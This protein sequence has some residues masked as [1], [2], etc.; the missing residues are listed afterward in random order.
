MKDNGFE[1]LEDG[2]I[3]RNVVPNKN[4]QDQ[5]YSEFQQLEY[6]V[7]HLTRPTDDPEKIARY[8]E[9]KKIYGSEKSD[10]IA[11]AQEKAK[12]KPI[13]S[14]NNNLLKAMIEKH[15]SENE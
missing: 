7:N 10:I 13:T 1:I 6:E 3:K 2:T 11:R 4:E 15:K 8:N 14:N 9:L 12:L 5:L